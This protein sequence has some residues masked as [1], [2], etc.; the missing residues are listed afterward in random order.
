VGSGPIMA[1][2]NTYPEYRQEGWNWPTG[3]MS[4]DQRHKVRVYASFQVPV[5]P[6]LGQFTVGA[7]Q[8]FD[9]GL[10]YDI[11]FS[12]DP[13]KYV[14]NP[15]YLKPPTSITYYISG[16]GPLRTDSVVSTDLSFV[17]SRK[18]RGSVEVF[19]RGLAF[20]IFNLQSIVEVN[21][22][23]SSNASPGTYTAASLPVFNPFT[24]TP[25]ADVNYRYGP[26]FGQPTAPSSYQSARSA[27][28]SV[29]IR[30]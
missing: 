17:W 2:I 23:V 10:P 25:V 6:N 7:V 3:Y 9:A 24:T 29:G 30:F 1:G 28:F 13:S 14:A 16:R 22:T 12:V 15:G 5:N 27:N 18:V 19:F 11:A 26:Q 20:N 21:T 4:N 8:R